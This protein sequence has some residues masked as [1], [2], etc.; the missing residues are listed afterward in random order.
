MAIP[1]R[2]I[3]QDSQSQLLWYITSQLEQ[4][5][6]IMGK[7]ANNTAPVTTTTTTTTTV[8]P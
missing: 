3:G 2:S 6:G 4:L 8:H 5:I 1:P 7:I